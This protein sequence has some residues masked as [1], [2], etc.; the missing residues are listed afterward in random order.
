MVKVIFF[1][2]KNET[3]NEFEIEINIILA[4]P[5]SQSETE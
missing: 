3:K 1:F 5:K 2:N 4:N